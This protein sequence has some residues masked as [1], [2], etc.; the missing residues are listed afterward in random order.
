MSLSPGARLGPYEILSPL[1][2]GGMGEVYA[3]RDTRLGRTV[4]IKRT[5]EQFSDRFQR[6]ARAISALNHPN[7]CQLYDVGP[8][9]LVMELVEGGP[10]APVDTPRKLLDLAVQMA[11]GLSAAHAAGIVHRDLKPD[12]ILVTRD[13]RVKLL[14][15]GLA[16]ERSGRPASD[17]ETRMASGAAATGSGV[18]VGTVAY[19]SP[20]QARGE[21]P[22]SAQSDQFSLGLVLYELAAGQRAFRRGSAA[23]TMTA[24]IREEPEPLPSTTPAP[25]RWVIERLLAKDPG[26]RYD[27]TRD[28]YRELRLIRD[29][30]SE[31]SGLTASADAPRARGRTRRR[32]ALAAAVLA[33]VVLGGALAWLPFL[34]PATASTND[35]SGLTFRPLATESVMEADPSWAPDGRTIA[36]VAM[37][38]GRSQI[39]TRSVD[40]GQAAQITRD[41][42]EA[43]NPAWA[44]DGSAIYFNSAGGLWVVGSAGGAP[45]RVF[46]RVG[47]YAIHPDGTTIVF[48]RAGAIWA[49]RRGEEPRELPNVSEIPRP[50]GLSGLAPDGSRFAVLT[51]DTV[52][53]V[54]YLTDAPPQHH[55]VSAVQAASWMPDSRRLAL[56]RIVG[57]EPHT[58]SM[59]DT[60]SGDHR[61][62]YANPNAMTFGA[63]SPDG[64]RLAYVAGRIEWNIVEVSTADARTRTLVAAGDTSYHP[65]WGPGGTRFAFMRYRGGRWSIEETSVV[66]GLS[67]RLLDIEQDTAGFLRMAP[68]GSQMTFMVEQ[69]GGSQLMLANLSGQTS[70]LD[71]GAPGPTSDAVWAPD[72]RHVIYLRTVPG[73]RIELARIRPGS[74]SAAEVLASHPPTDGARVRV[75]TAWSSDGNVI[76]TRSSGARQQYY[77]SPADFSSERPVPAERLCWDA[78]GLSNDGRT[79]LAI[80]RNTSVP[81]G[82]WQLWSVDAATG[83][84]RL[85]GNVDLPP[86]TERVSGFAMHP[87]GTRIITSV[88]ILPSDIWTLEGFEP[89]AQ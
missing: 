5:H 84:E 12:N 25:L 74:T 79:V 34:R 46:E 62:F 78:V 44:P 3:A 24:I 60:V 66:D 86:S 50:M 20:E 55:T 81:G 11:D 17:E 73:D 82:P 83:R 39:F 72:G 67:R 16:I 61:V 80:C 43:A 47:E 51:R 26:D 68:D 76:L 8:D 2:A 71:P 89:E 10:A 63:A 32:A 22:L 69:P 31:A 77:L 75:P 38:D 57:P 37:V 70:R 42:A 30:V 64:R 85:V 28:L 58:F 40:G 14:D 1:G 41:S 52:W 9:Y 56:T 13:G 6:E 45:D 18:I 33:G 59:L 21:A 54:P 35:L 65:D 88:G 19:M 48:Q 15:F 4:A 27:S 29:R 87:D 7:I 36:Y 49:G 23:E 53:I